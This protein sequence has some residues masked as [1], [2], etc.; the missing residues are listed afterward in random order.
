MD[1]VM[2]VGVPAYAQLQRVQER[3]LDDVPENESTDKRTAVCDE[4]GLTR[5]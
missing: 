5:K 4:F 2:D 1:S 3:E